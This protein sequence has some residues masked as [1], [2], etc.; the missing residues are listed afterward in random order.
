[1]ALA[2]YQLM[3]KN[4]PVLSFEYNLDEHKAVRITGIDQ[5]EAAPASNN[6]T[7]GTIY[8]LG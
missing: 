8:F 5:A 3:N 7:T 2:H 4:T 6:I 1:M